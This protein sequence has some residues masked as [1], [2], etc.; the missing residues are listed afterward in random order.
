MRFFN[1][2]ILLSGWLEVVSAIFLLLLFFT[3]G[4]FI[5]T[6]SNLLIL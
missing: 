6:L 5:I 2:M 4:L 1:E 3:K